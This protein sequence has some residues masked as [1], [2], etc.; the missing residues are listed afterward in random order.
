MFPQIPA[1]CWISIVFTVIT[2]LERLGGFGRL[3][4]TQI[5]LE[6]FVDS[7]SVFLRLDRNGER[8]LLVS[9]GVFRI[10]VGLGLLFQAETETATEDVDTVARLIPA[11]VGRAAIQRMLPHDRHAAHGIRPFLALADQPRLFVDNHRT[12]P[13]TTAKTLPCM[14][15]KPPSIRWETAYRRGF[16]SDTRL[17]CRCHR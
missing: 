11:T 8:L 17:S 15:M 1:Y 7:N 12:S 3:H 9:F 6:V 10:A 2:D 5:N 13:G 4:D 14:S 16:L